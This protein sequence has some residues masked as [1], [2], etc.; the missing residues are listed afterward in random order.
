MNGDLTQPLPNEGVQLILRS[1]ENLNGRMTG[2]ED[3]MMALEDKADRRLQET[4]PI[5]EQVLS[6]LDSVEARLDKVESEVYSLN[7]RFR[8]FT[9]D[10]IKVQDK[11]ED[12]EER[13]S[14]L[15]PEQA[16]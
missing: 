9:D 10:M 12:L 4:R 6:R 2:L 3:G 15:E 14:K 13:V 5:W 7:R 11:Q 16:Q 8:V 1:L